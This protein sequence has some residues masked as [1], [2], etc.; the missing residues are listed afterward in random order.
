[1]KHLRSYRNLALL[2][3]LLFSLSSISGFIVA[4]YMP[5]IESGNDLI[6]HKGSLRLAIDLFFNNIKVCIILMLGLFTFAIPTIFYLV[7]NGFFLGM[8]IKSLILVG[9]SSKEI[10][11]NLVPHA[12]LE[13]PAF[14]LAGIIGLNG[15]TFY[16]KPRIKL[17]PIFKISILVFILIFVA[18][19]IEGL[20]S[21]AL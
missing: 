10:A 8:G 16:F 4:N 14:L 21:A 19:M 5:L 1:M 15:L 20:L 7:F 13:I 18:A 2:A 6:N 17:K 12:V 3:V 11:I 9:L